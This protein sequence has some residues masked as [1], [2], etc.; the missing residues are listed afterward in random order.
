MKK[1][2]KFDVFL[3]RDKDV[4]LELEERSAI[5]NAL[6]CDA[7]ISIHV[8]S[9]KSQAKGFEIYY[10]SQKFSEYAFKIAQKENG[11]KMGKD[12]SIV[13]SIS[14]DFREDSSK[15]LAKTIAG[16]INKLNIVRRIEGAPFYVLAGTFCPSVLVELGFITNPEERKKLKDKNYIS[17]LVEKIYIAIE[18]FINS[19]LYQNSYL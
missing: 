13:F 6:E 12:E 7:F 2:G 4:F 19:Y 1:T 16:H 11:V 14:S 17:Q 9:S 5:A 10:F 18:E 3:T 8:N 15:K